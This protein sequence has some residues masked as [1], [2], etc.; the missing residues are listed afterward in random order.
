[1]GHGDGS[2]RAEPA[3]PAWLPSGRALAAQRAEP[4]AASFLRVRTRVV[5]RKL[6]IVMLIVGLTPFGSTGTYCD[7]YATLLPSRGRWRGGMAL[8]RRLR[9]PG[10][11]ERVPERVHC[12]RE[13]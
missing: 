5:T 3:L 11:I 6:V 2:R 8:I 9:M 1:V 12:G 7:T 13:V 4:T 10:S